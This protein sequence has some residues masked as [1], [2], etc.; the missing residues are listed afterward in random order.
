MKEALKVLSERIAKTAE[1]VKP[2]R[3]SLRGLH[4]MTDDPTN[5]EA[6]FT[7]DRTHALQDRMNSVCQLIYGELKDRNLVSQQSLM[8]Q[9][10]LSSDG[11]HAEVKLYATLMTKHSRPRWREDGPQGD[12]EAF[13]ASPLM[14]LFGLVDFGDVSLREIRL[15]CL[16]EEMGDDGY[17]RSLCSIPLSAQR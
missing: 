14:E 8:S 12:R 11:V 16:M 2:L 4:I 5:V 13:D 3:A 15:S 7:T 6:V 9:R 17:Y 1:F 10:V